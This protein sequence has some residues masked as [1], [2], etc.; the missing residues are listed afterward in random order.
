M[1]NHFNYSLIWTINPLTQIIFAMVPLHSSRLAKPTVQLLSCELCI[2]WLSLPKAPS[3]VHWALGPREK[4]LSNLWHLHFT[5]PYPSSSLVGVL[6]LC[7]FV[8]RSRDFWPSIFGYEYTSVPCETVLGTESCG[9]LSCSSSVSALSWSSHS[10]HLEDFALSWN[11]QRP[12]FWHSMC[13][14]EQSVNQ[15]PLHHDKHW[16]MLLQHLQNWKQ[17]WKHWKIVCRKCCYNGEF[18]YWWQVKWLI[19]HL[20]YLYYKLQA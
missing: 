15:I 20:S 10:P 9:L 6:L 1:I 3:Y 14:V 17:K 12:Q 2:F 4:Y 11:I 13:P 8:S 7:C 16:K 19:W 18:R 5:I